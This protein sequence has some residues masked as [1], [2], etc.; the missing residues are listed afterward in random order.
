MGGYS[1]IL[2]CLSIVSIMV[3]TKSKSD[4]AFTSSMYT[5][6]GQERFELIDVFVTFPDCG[7]GKAVRTL[8]RNH[9]NRFTCFE[10]FLC[11]QR[12]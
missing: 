3:F 10:R 2:P 9:L 1:Y 7:V 8:N 12:N 5:S 4:S 6:P 11:G